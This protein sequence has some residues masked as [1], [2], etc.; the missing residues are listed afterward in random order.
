MKNTYK[1][2][3]KSLLSNIEFISFDF[4]DNTFLFD[5]KCNTVD[6]IKNVTKLLEKLK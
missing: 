1:Q 3:I 5:E 6:A 4:E 2:N